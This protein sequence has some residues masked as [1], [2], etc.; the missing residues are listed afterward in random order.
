MKARMVEYEVSFRVWMSEEEN[1]TSEDELNNLLDQLGAVET[2]LVW[3]D[4]TWRAVWVGPLEEV[5]DNPH[6][7]EIPTERNI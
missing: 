7:F 5:T 4:A 6:T 2:D 3:D 1:T